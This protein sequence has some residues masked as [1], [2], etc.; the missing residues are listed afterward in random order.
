MIP[1]LL[2][3][4]ITVPLLLVGVVG[5]F[6]P[7]VPGLAFIYAGTALHKFAFFTPHPISWT[8]FALLT[9]I[10]VFAQ[11]LEMGAGFLG[12]K[13]QGMTRAGFW[14]GLA[15]LFIGLFL[16]LPGVILGPP[17][18]VF[19]GQHWVSKQ[20]AKPALRT[21]IAFLLGTA[22]GLVFKLLG[23]V[24]LLAVFALALAGYL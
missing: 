21:T 14:C 12:A 15:G 22:A 11:G 8:A 6:A 13:T 3:W 9:L 2:A 23:A 19:G 24:M 20:A 16:S 4:L 18:G 7:F 10:F 1:G 17:V 5:L